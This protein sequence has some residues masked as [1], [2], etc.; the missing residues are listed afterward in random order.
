MSYNL[1]LNSSNVIGSNNTEFRYNFING[2]F[3]IYEGA[4][5]CVS[6]VV[7]P[8]SFFNINNGYYQNATMQYIFGNNTYTITFPDGFYQ[9]SDLNKYIELYMINQNQY[10]Y[11]ATTGYNTYFIQLVTNVTY[12]SN[13]LI[14]LLYQPHYQKNFQQDL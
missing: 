4:K 3:K 12:Y 10:L 5:M 14:Y 2:N 8:Y 1:V 7:I 11:N 13:Q 9:V 6:Q